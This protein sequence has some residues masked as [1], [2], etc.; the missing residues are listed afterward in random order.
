MM[1]P[2]L[3]GRPLRRLTQRIVSRRRARDLARAVHALRSAGADRARHGQLLEEVSRAWGNEAY[4]ADL[5]FVRQVAARAEGTGPFLDCGSGAS[6]IVAAAL[7]ERHG[8][9]VWS[10]EQDAGWHATMRATLDALGLTNVE[11]CLAPLQVYDDFVWFGV[12]AVSLPDAFSHVFCDGPAVL[13]GAWP[14][15]FYSSWRAGVV[16][17]LQA[18]RV[19]FGEIVLDDGDDPRAPAVC[20]RWEAAGLEISRVETPTGPFIVARPRGA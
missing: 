15:P 14:D 12:D 3:L 4:A 19:R 18:R 9:R 8:G 17:V 13:P 5:G 7:A 16:P 11:L 10:L 20:R 1:L 2:P 6:T